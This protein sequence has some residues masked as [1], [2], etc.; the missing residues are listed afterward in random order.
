MRSVALI[1]LLLAPHAQALVIN[2]V[3][4]YGNETVEW[5]EIYNND[6]PVNISEW[7]IEDNWERDSI[8]CSQSQCIVPDEY[9][10]ITGNKIPTGQ[11]DTNVRHFHVDDTK[12][13]NGLSDN[14]SVKLI[15]SGSV[16]SQ[17]FY[18]SS[19]EDKSWCLIDGSIAQCVPTPGGPNAPPAT[20]TTLEQ[21]PTTTTIV[22][23]PTTRQ[24]QQAQTD[25]SIKIIKISEVKEG[26][27]LEVDLSIYRG[28][29][30]KYA[31][32]VWVDNAVK[33]IVHAKEKYMIY[34]VRLPVYVKD[35]CLDGQRL[36]IEGFG[37]R[38]EILIPKAACVQKTAMESKQ[39]APMEGGVQMK[40]LAIPEQFA[41]GRETEINIS[42]LNEGGEDKSIS[43]YSYFYWG[44]DLA[45][46][47]WDGEK[48]AGG[49][50]ANR[51]DVV[52]APG[53]INLTLRN[54]IKDM[55]RG[56]YMLKVKAKEG[57]KEYEFEKEVHINRKETPR[58]TTEI[59]E[60]M[61]STTIRPKIPTGLM[62]RRASLVERI[63]SRIGSLLRSIF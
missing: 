39:K 31:V 4:P 48:W 10:I 27:P 6:G 53:E 47:G 14:D 12:I 37:I 30:Q 38:Q 16:V 41:G 19:K 51:Q 45:S 1:L 29:T 44:N 57:D 61:T 46:L 63:I 55:A 49:W 42:L 21:A 54:M 52:L 28:D 26:E 24:A 34:E 11:I 3:M 60:P 58:N 22:A 40:L 17:F 43:A 23:I 35:P 18:T 62:V 15:Y 13:G 33:S 59:K 25:S 2:E 56:K 50:T 32:Y 7:V 5:V 9:F 36:V 20:T 8:E